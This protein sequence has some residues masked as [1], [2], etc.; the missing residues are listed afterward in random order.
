MPAKLNLNEPLIIKLYVDEFM[1]AP[2]L[3]KM[4]KCSDVTIMNVLKRNA[5]GVRTSREQQL[6]DAGIRDPKIIG[7]LYM[8]GTSTIQIH[9]AIGCDYE[10]ILRVLDSLGIPRNNTYLTSGFED[11]VYVELI[12]IFPDVEIK[13]NT[14]K[15][16]SG[17]ELDFYIPEYKLGIEF[18]GTYWHSDRFVNS[19]RHFEKWKM[20]WEQ[21]VILISI[22]EDDWI[23]SRE[24]VLNHIK[25]IRTPEFAVTS[26][27]KTTVNLDYETGLLVHRLNEGYVF[28]NWTPNKRRSNKLTYYGCGFLEIEMGG[29]SHVP[30]RL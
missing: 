27:V 16:L 2:K 22:W 7:D 24:A 20:C 5:V 21:N 30:S 11:D 23:K 15:V 6:A 8:S 26:E 1:S 18:N 10:T 4:F 28:G 29:D 3:A 19:K 12:Q 17:L 13:R 9:K 25:L 14:R